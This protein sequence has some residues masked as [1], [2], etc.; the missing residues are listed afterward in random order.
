MN[1]LVQLN[2]QYL[3]KHFLEESLLLKDFK[4]EFNNSTTNAREMFNNMY[5]DAI[6]INTIE[7][8]YNKTLDKD[9][10]KNS[11][12]DWDF[13]M[14]KN[15]TPVNKIKVLQLENNEIRISDDF[16]KDFIEKSEF[17]KTKIETYDNE[18]IKI[19]K[20]YDDN[21]KIKS[22]DNLIDKDNFEYEQIDAYNQNI[23]NIDNNFQ[24]D[25]H[26]FDQQPFDES[27]NNLEP[28]PNKNENH[29][30]KSKVLSQVRKYNQ[31]KRQEIEDFKKLWQYDKLNERLKA[32]RLK[33]NDINSLNSTNISEIVF[34]GDQVIDDKMTND[35][36]YEKIK[37]EFFRL[38]R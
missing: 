3:E 28:N 22:D 32:E 14:K 8:N 1:I 33:K 18:V 15:E 17:V 6:K 21:K 20:E 16:E 36:K 31:L 37:S 34:S 38:Q 35:E 23:E 7:G 2:K 30:S 29:Y 11:N 9:A 25:I 26:S 5:F 24:N 19:S 27:I 13:N 12:T 4:I 10:Y